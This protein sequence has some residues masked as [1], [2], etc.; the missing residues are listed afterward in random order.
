METMDWYEPEVRELERAR[1]RFP[2]PAHPVVFY[3][4]SSVRLWS[5]LNR[6]LRSPRLVNLGF[7]GSTLAACVYFF[8]RLVLPV[9][10]AALLVYAGDNDL[11]DGRSPDEVT[12]SFGQLAAKVNQSFGPI[13]FGFLSIK[14]S[15]ARLSILHH[16][17]ETNQRIRRQIAEIPGAF[18]ID[19]VPAMMG[20]D[21][22]P[23]PDL[24]QE[25]GL[26]LSDVGYQVWTTLLEPYRHCIFTEDSPGRN[27]ECVP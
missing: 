8:E 14:P 26:H 1:T 19:L 6:D 12:R 11:G 21:G 9:H 22:Q 27:V 4:S 25:D 5:T 24:F 17:Q 10:P 7:G 23:R 20:P 2:L 16:I 15:P 3:G 13:P 18:F